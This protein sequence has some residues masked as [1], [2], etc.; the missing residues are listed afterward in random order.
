MKFAKL[1]GAGND[2]ALIE[3]QTKKNNWSQL[4]QA[5]CNRRFGI[6]ADGLLLL[7][8]SSRADFRMRMFNPDGSEAEACGNGLRCLCRYILEKRLTRSAAIRI[9]TAAGIRDARFTGRGRSAAI[10]VSMGQP[11]FE[12]SRIPVAVGNEQS[13]EPILGY[14]LAIE[15]TPLELDFISMGNP[16]AVYFWSKPVIDFPLDRIGPKVENHEIFPRRVNF[17]VARRV[18]ES[19]I[20]LRVWERGAGETQA[21]GTGACAVAVASQLHGYTGRKVDMIVPG[22]TLNVEWDGRGEVFL[23]GPAELVF[24]GNWKEH[25]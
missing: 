16:H 13:G 2:F 25:K 6:G 7:L 17:E 1:Q 21:C 4:A 9:E 11:V 12:A 22:G 24:T 10:Q 18:D 20:E 23:G 14:P 3:P 5:M 15:G 19:M 8:P